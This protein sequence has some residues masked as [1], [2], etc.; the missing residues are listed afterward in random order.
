MNK[1]HEHKLILVVVKRRLVIA[2]NINRDIPWELFDGEIQGM[3]PL[4]GVGAVIFISTEKKLCIKYAIGQSTNN[5]EELTTLW[6]ILRV[7][8]SRQILDIQIFSD[9]KMVVDLENAR[10]NIR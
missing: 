6:A 7:S 9:S 3:P 8:L 4:G 2:P 1:I 5:K 10:N